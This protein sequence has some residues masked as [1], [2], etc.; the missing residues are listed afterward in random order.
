MFDDLTIEC[1][2]LQLLGLDNEEIRGYLEFFYK[3]DI[4]TN[5]CV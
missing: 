2:E 3:E 1:L 5:E 4:T